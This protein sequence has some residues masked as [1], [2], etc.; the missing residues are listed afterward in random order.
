M[1]RDEEE[2]TN[3]VERLERERSAAEA[4][5]ANA[6]TAGTLTPEDAGRLDW[7]VDGQL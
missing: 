4:L 7:P 1:S 6:P 3:L 5:A 2:L